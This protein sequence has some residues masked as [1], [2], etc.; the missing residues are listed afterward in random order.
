[1]LKIR[2]LSLSEASLESGMSIAA[3]KVAVHRAIKSLRKS[4][5]RNS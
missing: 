3:L 2:E 4:V 5:P 1:M